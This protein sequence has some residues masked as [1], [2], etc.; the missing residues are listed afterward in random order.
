MVSAMALVTHITPMRPIKFLNLQPLGLTDK[1]VMTI[2]DSAA[3]N[4]L[5]QALLNSLHQYAAQLQGRRIWLAC[6]GGRDSLSLAW[7]CRQLFDKGRMPFLPQLIHVNHGLQTANASWAQQVQDWASQHAMPCTLLTLKLSDANRVNEQS[8]RHARYMA[9]MDMMNKDDVLMLGHHQDDQVETVL[10]RLFKGAG[11]NGLAGM[12]D[13]T[14]FAMSRQTINPDN[15]KDNQKDNYQNCY[16]ANQQNSDA[17]YLKSK[18][19]FNPN[20]IP[21]PI[22]N[23][24]IVL[25]RPWLRVSRATITD[26]AKYTK[27][28]Y[29]DDPTNTVLTLA[30]ANTNANTNR[31][32]DITTNIRA[33]DPTVQNVSDWVGSSN[34]DTKINDRA[35]LRSV[36]MP[37]IAQRYPQVNAA[38][39]RTSQI[40]QATSSIID[41]QVQIDLAAVSIAPA[42]LQ[43]ISAMQAMLDIMKLQML[44]PARQAA[45]IHAWLSPQPT[46]LPPSKTMVDSVLALSLRAD[47]DHQTVLYYH[48]GAYHYEIRRYQHKLYRLRSDWQHW[49]SITPGSQYLNIYRGHNTYNTANDDTPVNDTPVNDTPVNDTPVNDTPVNDMLVNDMLVNDFEHDDQLSLKPSHLPFL[50][51]LSSIHCLIKTLKTARHN[52][53]ITPGSRL[54]FEPLPRDLKVTLAARVGRKS[55]KKLLQALNQPVFMRSSL[56]LGSLVQTIAQDAPQADSAATQRIPLFIIAIDRIYWLEHPFTA[57]LNSNIDTD[58]DIKRQ[59]LSTQILYHP[60]YL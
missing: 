5:Q 57:V 13:W 37:V 46:E 58:T 47:N 50:W 19:V 14:I 43:N 26:Y 9:M 22:R 12:Q 38:I 52:C 60:P 3:T 1:N 23:K 31:S 40:M 7:M 39:A 25:W 49:L 10:M 21:T 59:P 53:V 34:E 24:S 30:N 36:L 56:V 35:W 17:A 32:T 45:L 29:I 48:S 11:V 16:N 20:S 33:D 28:D 4:V 41:E 42:S 8:A 27:L 51:Q 55:G 2:A 18:A 6:S 44:L 15:Q 54:Y